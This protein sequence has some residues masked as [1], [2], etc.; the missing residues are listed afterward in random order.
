MNAAVEAAQRA[1]VT[2]SKISPRVRSRYL[3]KWAALIQ[4]NKNDL[5]KIITYE[6]GK[7]LAES[8]AELDYAYNAAWWFAGEADRIQGTVF[9]S[10]TPSKKVMTIKQP[11]GV[12]AALV[13]WNFP[14][15]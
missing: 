10:S 4:E 12:V 14:V 15:A 3:H 11:I 9:D 7:P 13:P 5:A 6:N 2:Y 8:L 1:F